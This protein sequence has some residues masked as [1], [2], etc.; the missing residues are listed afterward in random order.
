MPDNGYGVYVW[1]G[2]SN[3]VLDL[4]KDLGVKWVAIGNGAVWHWRNDTGY[5]S[6]VV[7]LAQRIRQRG[8]EPYV[9][10]SLHATGQPAFTPAD[11]AS[12]AAFAAERVATLN[13]SQTVLQAEPH[14]WSS[15]VGTPENYAGLYTTAYPIIKA[16]KADCTVLGSYGWGR[17]DQIYNDGST[18][19]YLDRLVTAGLFNSVDGLSV[20]PYC[21]NETPET[22]LASQWTSL[23]A[24]L[25]TKG[26]S[27]MP[28]Y[29]DE[30]GFTLSSTPAGGGPRS[31]EEQADLVVRT[32][33]TLHDL[34]DT[35]IIYF[36][37][38]YTSKR[39]KKKR[40]I[41]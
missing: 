10:I 5:M 2:T 9:D 40:R 19:Y 25:A 27:G 13:L 18:T 33:N 23:Q 28:I 26:K 38:P 24:Y 37:L 20:H 29:F 30:W 15:Y 14:T 39:T 12:I 34:D 35:A 21:M 7:S 17:M 31:E 22:Y 41:H 4:A 36:Y 6:G 32:A 3:A 11:Y 16:A 1:T 8:M